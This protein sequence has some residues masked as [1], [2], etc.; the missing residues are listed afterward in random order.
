MRT[1]KRTKRQ[2]EQENQRLLCQYLDACGADYCHP[3]NGG[4]RSKVEAA[5]F[6]GIGVKAGVPDILIFSV[7]PRQPTPGTVRGIAIEL[8]SPGGKT[9]PEQ[10]EWTR[11]LRGN[12]WAVLVSEG[13]GPAID[14]LAERFG[15]VPGTFSKE[16]PSEDPEAF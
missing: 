4:Q 14:W 12:G 8:K 9:S 11:R 10:D 3:A 15:I 1:K 6:K 7:P 5:I 2:V 16:P 13:F